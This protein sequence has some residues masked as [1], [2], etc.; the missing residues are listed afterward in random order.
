VNVSVIWVLLGVLYFILGQLCLVPFLRWTNRWIWSTNLQMR[1]CFRFFIKRR[2]TAHGRQLTAH[3]LSFERWFDI[4]SDSDSIAVLVLSNSCNIWAQ[5]DCLIERKISTGCTVR[6]S[7]KHSK[8]MIEGV[9]K[10]F[11]LT[12]MPSS[13]EDKIDIPRIGFRH[14][15]YYCRLLA[16]V[17]L[18]SWWN[19]ST[20]TGL[21]HCG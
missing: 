5:L 3:D 12:I 14:S 17:S 1:P 13:A 21:L 11:I 6:D 4:L 20:R 9:R 8:V 19:G 7:E 16:P 2:S 18:H 10:L 15:P